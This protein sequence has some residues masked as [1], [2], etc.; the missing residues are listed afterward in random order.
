MTMRIMESQ[1]VDK[2]EYAANGTKFVRLDRGSLI[3]RYTLEIAITIRT[4]STSFNASNTKRNGLLNLIKQIRLEIG[5]GQLKFTH[6]G[7]D[8]YFTDLYEVG[9]YP[10]MDPLTNIPANSSKTFRI[11]FIYDFA[12]SRRTMSDFRE[13]LNAPGNPSND[14][15]VDWG[16]MADVMTGNVPTGIEIDPDKTNITISNLRA[17][18]DGSG[19]SQ[20]E[21]VLSNLADPRVGVDQFLLDRAATSYDDSIIRIP[22]NPVRTLITEQVC[23]ALEN[24]TDGDPRFSNDVVDQFK[25]ENVVGG[26]E[27]IIQDWWR[28][29]WYQNRH[30]LRMRQHPEGIILLDWPDQRQGGLRN[31]KAEDL[32]IRLLTPPPAAGKK[33]AI[34]IHY[35][36]YPLPGV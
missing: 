6:S 15:Y 16:S 7:T 33:N 26:K 32:E 4:G 24:I 3:R 14:L 1:I 2:I 25:V 30:D 11:W 31:N 9:E 19:D 23:F 17:F 22:I 36:Y 8:K 18:E 27:T 5:A 35:K 29:I 20:I 13:L 28:H 12:P 34:R 10:H 21:A